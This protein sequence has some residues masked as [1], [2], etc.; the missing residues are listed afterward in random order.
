MENR[1]YNNGLLISYS[2]LGHS[3]HVYCIQSKSRN[4]DGISR[5]L[6]RNMEKHENDGV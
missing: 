4:L 3:Y 5:R 2:R 6:E 1:I